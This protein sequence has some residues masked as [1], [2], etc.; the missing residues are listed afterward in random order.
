MAMGMD[1]L[2]KTAI[3]SLGIDP[4]VLLAQLAQWL[5]WGESKIND[6]D[7]RMRNMED[8]NRELVEQNAQFIAYIKACNPA[9]N[10]P[11]QLTNETE[12][13]TQNG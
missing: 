12:K 4:E 6:F 5:K 8:I 13:E 10:T 2:I 7:A 1:M 3:K 11:P 9:L